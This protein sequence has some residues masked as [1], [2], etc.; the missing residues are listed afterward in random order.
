MQDW[1]ALTCRQIC[2]CTPPAGNASSAD[3]I[4]K[5]YF[6]TDGC[7]RHTQLNREAGPAD[8]ITAVISCPAAPP[9]SV[10]LAVLNKSAK[11]PGQ[12]FS[13]NCWEEGYRTV[14]APGAS[15]RVC[16][17]CLAQT[18]RLTECGLHCYNRTSGSADS[19]HSTNS[20]FRSGG[21]SATGPCP[22]ACVRVSRG[23]C[24]HPRHPLRPQPRM[25]DPSR[26]VL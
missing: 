2:W 11:A 17:C 5:H 21:M 15:G 4:D 9:G 12:A 6:N 22:H 16:R 18:G 24:Q 23:G 19:G 26:R 13:E 25:P 14:A 20:D 3:S 1:Q 8:R 10:D 7:S